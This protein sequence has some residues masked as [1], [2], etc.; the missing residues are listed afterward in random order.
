VLGVSAK[1]LKALNTPARGA[2][3]Q[4]LGVCRAWLVRAA[5]RRDAS[6]PHL[7][8]AKVAGPKRAS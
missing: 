1:G 3:H 6:L 5:R 8:G 4:S 2:Q 7:P